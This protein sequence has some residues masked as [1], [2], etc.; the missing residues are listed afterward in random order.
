MPI[1][2]TIQILSTGETPVFGPGGKVT[3][4]I[5]TRWMYGTDHGPYTTDIPKDSFTA[6]ALAA[7]QKAITQQLDLL[8]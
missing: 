2:R 6:A 4:M 3:T 8:P 1:A 5:R 7:A